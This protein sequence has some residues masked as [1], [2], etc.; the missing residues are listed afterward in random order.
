MIDS[1]A[2]ALELTGRPF[3]EVGECGGSPAVSRYSDRCRP[4]LGTVMAMRTFPQRQ[5][6]ART[7]INRCLFVVDDFGIGAVAAIGMFRLPPTIGELI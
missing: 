4:A 7:P 6:P 3:G 5:D 1:A 2:F